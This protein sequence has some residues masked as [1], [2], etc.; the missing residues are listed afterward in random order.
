MVAGFV[1]GHVTHPDASPPVPDSGVP[2]S[3][4]ETPPQSDIQELAGLQDLTTLLEAIPAP[5]LPTGT[6]RVWGRVRDA[7]GEPLPDVAVRA[8]RSVPLVEGMILRARITTSKDLTTAVREFVE[9]WRTALVPVA[10]STTDVAGKFEL[11]GLADEELQVM[12]YKKGYLVHADGLAYVDHFRPG[13]SIDFVA[14]PIYP[15]DV[16]VRLPDESRPAQATLFISDVEDCSDR[17]QWT[18]AEMTI[19]LPAGE[20]SVIA[21]V[22]DGIEETHRSVRHKFVVGAKQTRARFTL[23]LHD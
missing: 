21:M 22:R 12:A 6:G 14:I 11:R 15:V 13:A 2:H 19:W 3:S 20:Y 18:P 7:D 23:K 1:V 5:E 4:A 17:E 9:Y 16:D 8:R 10:E